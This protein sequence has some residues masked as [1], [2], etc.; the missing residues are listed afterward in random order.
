MYIIAGWHSNGFDRV[1]THKRTG[2]GSVL[3]GAGVTANLGL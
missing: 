3:V 1:D 2:S